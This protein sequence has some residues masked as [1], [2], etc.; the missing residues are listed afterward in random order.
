MSYIMYEKLA[1]H[2]GKKEYQATY[3]TYLY[4]D[5]TTVYSSKISASQQGYVF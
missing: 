4:T 2:M 3:F 5:S 1:I